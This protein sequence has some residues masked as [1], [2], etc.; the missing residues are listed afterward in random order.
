LGFFPQLSFKT[1]PF[2]KKTQG[3]FLIETGTL[4][5]RG[6]WLGGLIPGI[7]LLWMEERFGTF[8]VK[9]EGD[10]GLTLEG[11]LVFQ[12]FFPHFL[13]IS[14]KLASETHFFRLGPFSKGEGFPRKG[15]S[16]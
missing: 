8:P 13:G 16:F 9:K 15:F 7:S 5:K 14:P 1:L 4:R 12:T 6:S 11:T 10:C 3:I 2:F